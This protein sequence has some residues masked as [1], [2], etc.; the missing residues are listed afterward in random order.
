MINKCKNCGKTTPFEFICSH[1]NKEFCVDCRLPETHNCEEFDRK[2][3][4]PLWKLK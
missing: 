1:C 2:T 3:A 4:T